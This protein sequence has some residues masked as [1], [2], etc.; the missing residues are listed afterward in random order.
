MPAV[1]V[2]SEDAKKDR[3][4]VAFGDSRCSICSGFGVG[5]KDGPESNGEIVRRRGENLRA[6]MMKTG[7]LPGARGVYQY[8]SG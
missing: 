8:N 5:R 4:L 1:S 7:G 2:S 6:R 3:P